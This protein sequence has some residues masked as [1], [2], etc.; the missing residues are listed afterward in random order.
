LAT[1]N[2]DRPRRL[3]AGV[4]TAVVIVGIATGILLLP[5]VMNLG[6][7]IGGS[8]AILG[9]APEVARRAS[10]LSVQELLVGPGSFTFAATTGGPPFYGLA[11]AAHMRNVRVVVYGFFGLVLAGA[12]AVAFSIG[13]MRRPDALRAVRLGA[14]GVVLVFVAIGIGLVVAFDAL[15]TL[16]H[17]IVFPAGG[18]EFDATT[19]RIVQLYPT[20]FWEFAAGTLAVVSVGLGLLVIAVTTLLLRRSEGTDRPASEVNAPGSDRRR[21][22]HARR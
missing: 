6:L 3:V 4:G 11:E 7:E 12:V 9:V 14:T 1:Q 13:R 15:F 16:F 20:P 19:Q 18:W 10:E 8:A 22:V 2:S 5:P 21:T 17:R